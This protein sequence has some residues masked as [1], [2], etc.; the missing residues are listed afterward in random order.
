[1]FRA[2]FITGALIL[3]SSVVNAKG[4]GFGG[5]YVTITPASQ[6]GNQCIAEGVGRDQ[7]TK[8]ADG[9]NVIVQGVHGVQTAR[10]GNPAFPILAT[11]QKVA[12]DEIRNT[13][14]IQCVPQGT[15]AGEEVVLRNFGRATVLEI[16]AA[17]S[18][19]LGPR[20]VHLQAATVISTA[21]YRAQ[22]AAARPGQSRDD[23]SLQAQQ[24]AAVK[25]A[26][27][28]D[29]L[30][31]E[32]QR[33]VAS[34]AAVEEFHVRHILL[35][36]REEA[37]AILDKVRAGEP[38]AILARASRDPSSGVNGGDL[39]WNV[40]KYF[41][42]QFSKAMVA[43]KPSG[44]ARDPVRTRFGWHV[45]EV[46][47]VKMGKDSF[48]SYADVKERIAAK[49]AR[50][51]TQ[52][53]A[54]AHAA[55]VCRKMVPVAP[56][57]SD[58]PRS[59]GTVLAEMKIERGRVSEV[60]SLTGPAIFHPLVKAAILKYECDVMDRPIIGTQSFTFD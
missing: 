51:N 9:T 21:A 20:D 15:R 53:L 36:T 10:C 49:L 28:E 26:P 41:D 1:M 31:R 8:A 44:L 50:E 47:E 42:E 33:L 19:C 54:R 58:Q 13:P 45:I 11:V 35:Q 6:P 46:L 24:D 30:R 48:P 25:P 4:G 37:Q 55:A 59:S 60:V 2:L 32:Y 29:E 7:E 40:P 17:S 56:L 27:S 52:P 38:F 39:G 22:Q 16:Q 5:Y 23:A 18:E 14:S 43:L 57:A 3:L 12:P 34:A